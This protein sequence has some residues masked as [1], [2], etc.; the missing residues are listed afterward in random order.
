MTIEIENNIKD[1]ITAEIE[2]WVE[3]AKFNRIE[4]IVNGVALLAIAA[5]ALAAAAACA[6]IAPLFTILP[7]AAA[8]A[9]L[10]A[11]VAYLALNIQGEKKLFEEKVPVSS[12]IE[13]V[14]KTP[15]STL[16][17]EEKPY[18]FP[19]N[20]FFDNQRGFRING[21]KLIGKNENEQLAS[22]M[23]METL[24]DKQTFENVA[25][26][27]NQAIY[28]KPLERFSKLAREEY[29]L[30]DFKEPYSRKK[31]LSRNNLIV[32]GN[33]ISIDCRERFRILDPMDI[34]KRPLG[35]A[36][37]TIRGKNV[38]KPD[39]EITFTLKVIATSR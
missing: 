8:L 1:K 5:V 35:Y 23:K 38:H 37:V 14:R 20:F 18:T 28:S 26:L 10:V 4:K 6:L 3:E 25:A 29:I 30:G 39:A 32:K 27:Y 11:G 7:L 24:K 22:L 16:S 34:E 33:N 21:A 17:Y 9:F 13:E 36:E 2:S 15:S 31:V 19:G 12:L